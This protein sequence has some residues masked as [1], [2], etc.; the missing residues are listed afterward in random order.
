MTDFK[1]HIPF[2]KPEISDDEIREV[3]RVLKSGWLTGGPE[4]SLFEKEFAETLSVK[5]AVALNSATAA[6][7]LA[8]HFHEIGQGDA[9]ICPAI[10]FAATATTALMTG[11]IPFF[12]DVDRKSYLLTADSIEKFIKERCVTDKGRWPVE[13]KT[14]LNIKAVLPVHLA[15]RVCDIKAI[16]QVADKYNLTVIEDAAHAFPAKYKNGKSVGSS[17]HFA[18]FSFYA[19]KNLTS[20]EGGMLTMNDSEA[21]SR[22]RCIRQ[23]G[24]TANKTAGRSWAYTIDELGFKYN[25]NDIAAAIGRVQLKKTEEFYK[26]RKSISDYYRDS[27]KDISGLSGMPDAMEGESYHIFAVEI[28]KDRDY[29]MD[30]LTEKGIG[31]SL[32]FTPLYRHP[33]FSKTGLYNESEFPVSEEIFKR[34]VSLPLSNSL[35]MEDAHYVSAAVKEI[36]ELIN[37]G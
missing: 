9:V 13:K 4:V 21:A 18:A 22:L 34:S 29:F 16:E 5:E 23:H 37:H 35:S 17:G 19:T 33:V 36:L 32:H 8:L 12:A 1:K 27:L 11:A 10:T 28:E 2:S 6:L 20:G 3:S 31:I 30:Q 15:G 26:H 25:M 7:H 14:G 24:M